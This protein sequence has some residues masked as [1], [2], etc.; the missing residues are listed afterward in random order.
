MT[1][2]SNK[3][4][5]DLVLLVTPTGHYQEFE[6]GA[7]SDLLAHKGYKPQLNLLLPESIVVRLMHAV[8]DALEKGAVRLVNYSLGIDAKQEY[9]EAK[10]IPLHAAYALLIIQNITDHVENRKALHQRNQLLQTVIDSVPA[11][12]AAYDNKGCITLINKAAQQ[13]SQTNAHKTGTETISLKPDGETE[14]TEK[15]LPLA[16]GFRGEVVHNQI[17]I[18]KREV[19]NKRTY[20]TNAVPLKDENGKVNG[21]VLTERDITDVKEIQHK[22]KTKIKD[23]DM[24]MYR[25][26]HDLKSPLASM[27]GVLTFAWDKL[28]DP[29]IR[30][31]L[32]M[33]RKSHS[34]LS[35]IVND[36][37]SLTRIAQKEIEKTS[38]NLHAFITHITEA[39][40]LIPAAKDIKI[41][42]CVQESMTVYAD[43]S[44]LRAILQNLICN[45]IMHHHSAG[46][47]RFVLITAFNQPNTVRLEVTDN[48]PGIAKDIQDKVFDVFYRGNPTTQGSGLGL[49]IVKQAIEKMG[50]TIELAS[51][52]EA[53]AT[54]SVILPKHR[55]NE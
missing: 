45:A 7:I 16:R 25:A 24:F 35:T 22:L 53:G 50:A 52:E 42:V 8:T 9:F 31:Y 26:S 30:R 11:E 6:T 36:L 49:F 15:E 18:K 2:S 10:A 41:K 23:L 46:D 19:D 1:V 55:S 48:G 44:L 34:L 54:F 14:F 20:L 13:V 39:L 40:S 5:T 47:D 3:V 38:I 37:I 17:V 29:E 12:I 32:L 51:E 27:E 33:I 21:V 4:I 43:E 28:E